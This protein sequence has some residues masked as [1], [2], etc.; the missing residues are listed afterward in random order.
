MTTLWYTQPATRWTEALPLGNGRLGAMVFGGI[1][2]ERIALNDDTLWSGGPT[3]W[4][5]PGGP[6]TLGE[7]RQFLAA[8]DYARADEI[9]K[10]MMGP[11]TQSYLP[12][13]DL[14][15][16]FEHV[17]QADSY[18]RE[19]NLADAIAT[20]SYRIGNT[21]YAREVLA[22]NPDQ[23]IAIHLRAEGP[24]RF[25]LRATLRSQLRWQLCALAGALLLRGKAP[26]LVDPSYYRR[27]KFVYEDD[28]EGMRFAAMLRASEC[29]GELSVEQ[30]ELRIIGASRL[31]LLL[32][33]ATSFNGF[34][35]S[36]T[37]HGRDEQLVAATYLDA[38]RRKPYETLRATHVQDH[39]R[40]FER[41]RFELG[42]VDPAQKDLPTD[43]RLER[44]G[45]DPRLVELMFQYGRY[46]LIASSRPGDQ[47]AN[48]QGI[49]NEQL[50]PPWSCNWTTNINVEM[51]YWPAEVA[52]L[53]E[54]H[55]PLLEMIRQ[56]SINGCQTAKVNYGCR[57]WTAHH[58][59]DLWRQ[60]APAGNYGE[61][62]ADP[63]WAV[64]PMAG[65]WLCQHL[66][67]HYAFGGD[68]GYLRRHAYPVMK[69]ACEF[70][71]DFLIEDGQGHLITSPSTSPEHK[72]IA[73]DGQKRCLSIATTCD[74]SLIWDLF[75]NTI[76][77]SQVLGIDE[78]FRQRLMEARGKLLAPRIGRQGRLQ[79]WSQDFEDSEPQHRH[80]SHL[81]GV[82]PGRQWTRDTHPELFAA[83]RRSLELRGNG[84]TGWSL[85]WKINLWARLGDAEQAMQCIRALL[86][87][88]SDEQ[89][90]KGGLYPNLFDA[91]PPFQIDGNF[92]FTAGV[93]EMLLQSHQTG[94][95]Q[96]GSHL[97]VLRLL[98][99]L[100]RDWPQ[101]RVSGLRARGGFQIDLDWR[102]GRLNLARIRSLLGNACLVHAAGRTH[103]LRFAAGEQR[104]LSRE[105]LA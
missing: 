32:S 33:A 12:L 51:N 98:P 23:V 29:D 40:L 27:G 97:V 8:A 37:R 39:R 66:W 49:W 22:S 64:W 19:L 95:A 48:L 63:V 21:R 89:R 68:E 53:A 38:A 62:A 25:N 102:D 86:N 3:D 60:S 58:N 79:E 103:E 75:S 43:Q 46:L 70:F 24:G 31:T 11:Y 2:D 18:R 10:R 104:T 42:S 16:H 13:G 94:V 96:D 82:H 9:S 41:V 54:C 26:A 5:N 65:A 78:P 6:K 34:D 67:E 45:D 50:R 73:P 36:P 71:L 30:G 80:M 101:G 72:F 83:A 100:P 14:E 1:A 93:C 20:V 55:W 105:Q 92:G 76:Q 61:P 87:P 4:N 52:N 15:L 88:V 90:W 35:K 69:Q 99:A 28:G 91:H 85:A 57:G 44:G 17:G 56:L 74:M 81:F 77:A 59:T 84:G 7:V 47:P